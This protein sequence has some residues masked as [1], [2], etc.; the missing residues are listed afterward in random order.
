MLRTFTSALRFASRRSYAAQA[1]KKSEDLLLTLASPNAVSSCL[2][3]LI[4]RILSLLVI[5]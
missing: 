2:F 3:C 4:F 1:E 5:S